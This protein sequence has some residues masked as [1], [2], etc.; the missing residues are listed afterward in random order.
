M[1]YVPDNENDRKARFD[2]YLDEYEKAL[3]RERQELEQE[4]G[5]TWF[6]H[7]ITGDEAAD[8]LDAVLEAM[9]F[10]DA[11]YRVG[12]LQLARMQ[13]GDEL[14]GKFVGFDELFCN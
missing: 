7:E 13:E 12:H 1:A 3:E 14:A 6:V 4:Y 10:T 9:S 2:E 5:G 8:L 11:M